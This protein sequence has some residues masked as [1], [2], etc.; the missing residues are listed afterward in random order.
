M[1]W[2][3]FETSIALLLRKDWTDKVVETGGWIVRDVKIR[4]WSER[5]IAKEVTLGDTVEKEWVMIRSSV[6]WWMWVGKWTCCDKLNALRVVR[7]CVVFELWRSS[8]WRLKSPVMRKWCG[9]VAA[10]D[11]KE[12]RSLKNWGVSWRFFVQECGWYSLI[13]KNL[14][15]RSLRST[16]WWAIKWF[17]CLSRRG[18]TS[19]ESQIRNTV[20]PPNTPDLLFEGREVEMSYIGAKWDQVTYFI[21]GSR[22]RYPSLSQSKPM[23]WWTVRKN[24]QNQQ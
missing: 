23:N 3:K 24:Q 13:T 17:E 9:V 1:S 16:S 18:K 22:R 21:M 2:E 5:K 11:I 15:P 12:L 19:Q 20:L 6:C 10:T 8:L 14:A 7:N 4:C